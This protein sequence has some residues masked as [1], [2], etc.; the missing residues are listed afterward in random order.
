MAVFFGS[1]NAANNSTAPTLS[2]SDLVAQSIE[3]LGG[4]ENLSQVSSVS[5]VGGE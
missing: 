2:A 1:T 3:A 5:Y 4:S